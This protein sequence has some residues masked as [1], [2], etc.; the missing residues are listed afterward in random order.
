MKTKYAILIRKGIILALCCALFF[1]GCQSEQDEIYSQ[2]MASQSESSML[3]PSSSTSSGETSE[4]VPDYV[5]PPTPG[6]DARLTPA[7]DD[8]LSGELV[9]RTYLQSTGDHLYWLAREFMELHPN[10]QILLDYDYKNSEFLSREESRMR[11]NSF[12]TN[13]RM[14][15]ASG[16]ADYLIYS[17]TLDLDFTPLARSG[18]LE[19]LWTYWEND[20][21]IRDED[22]FLPVI[23]SFEVD[24][25]LP[26]L[27]YSFYLTGGCFNKSYLE[28]LGVDLSAL[29]LVDSDD[30]LDWYERLRETHPDLQLFFTGTGK[31][32][33]FSSEL[34][35]YIDLE[36]NTASFDSPEFLTFLQRT[37][38]VINDEPIQDIVG[39]GNSYYMEMALH[40]GATGEITSYFVQNT[41]LPQIKNVVTKSRDSFCTT[42]LVNIYDTI[43][44]FQ[45]SYDYLA[46]PYPVLSTNGHLGIY[47]DHGEFMMPASMKNK[48]LAWEFM[49]YC[50]SEREDLTF[51]G[52]DD[53]PS[54]ATFF[55]STAIPLNKSNYGRIAEESV[56]QVKFV[57]G[58][59]YEVLDFE[60]VNGEE[61]VAFMDGVLSHSPVNIGKY[62]VDVQEFL[63]EY[64]V[65]ELITAEECADKIQGRVE[66]WLNE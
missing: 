28:E 24:G 8:D 40:Y 4:D 5:T 58:N 32:G 20:P 29:Q 38:D 27:P 9:I 37:Q 3:E 39:W 46:G 10:V 21:D 42:V 33:L 41:S 36:N 13:L 50:I 1:C 45:Q 11:E 64:Y 53:F 35:S 26:V 52:Y 43:S 60:P 62:N 25:M 49:K 14:E 55:T 61:I 51:N 12:Y 34:A 56:E 47:A 63:D 16:E 59:G 18:L 65:N 30:I 6:P 48:E 2:A 31:D 54:T 17:A 44:M 23:E 7:P 66:I 15:L 19:D 57:N 22:Y